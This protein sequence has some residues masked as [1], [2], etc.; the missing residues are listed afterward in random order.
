VYHVQGGLQGCPHLVCTAQGHVPRALPCR[1][2]DIHSLGPKPSEAKQFNKPIP[3]YSL[4]ATCTADIHSLC[5]K[6]SEAK[7]LNRPINQFYLQAT[8]TASGRG[9][10]VSSDPVHQPPAHRNLPPECPIAVQAHSL[11]LAAPEPPA[12][13]SAAEPCSPPSASLH[14]SHPGPVHDLFSNALSSCNELKDY[15]FWTRLRGTHTTAN[16]DAPQRTGKQCLPNGA[17]EASCSSLHAEK[18]PTEFGKHPRSQL[19]SQSKMPQNL[20]EHLRHFATIG[21][22]RVLQ[23]DLLVKGNSKVHT[24]WRL[25]QLLNL[26]Q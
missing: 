7:Q 1:A 3:Q 5:P 11:A 23:R 20:C 16:A 24:T 8:C 9:A 26:L 2:A 22:K 19:C 18:P 12:L 6:P 21:D 25:L 4:Q 14:G 17:C 10:A 15:L 13:P